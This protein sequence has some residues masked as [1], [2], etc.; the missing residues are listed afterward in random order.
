[1]TFDDVRKK[2]KRDDVAIVSEPM[3]CSYETYDSGESQCSSDECDYNDGSER[4]ESDDDSDCFTAEASNHNKKVDV[5][6]SDGSEDRFGDDHVNA[7]SICYNDNSFNID[8]SAA[9]VTITNNQS[10]VPNKSNCSTS[11]PAR[12]STCGSP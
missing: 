6:D 1:M 4:L 2:N 3:E 12:T 8:N 10:L 11:L 7:S 9:S 5:E